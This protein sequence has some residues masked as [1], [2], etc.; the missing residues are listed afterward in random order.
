[1]L[2]RY[3]RVAV[4]AVGAVGLF[5]LTA[6]SHPRAQEPDAAAL[7]KSACAQCHDGSGATRAPSPDALKSRSPESVVDALT[8][9]AMR[10][11][12]LQLTGTERRTLAEYLSGKKMGG[13]LTGVG[14][15]ARC[16]TVPAMTDPDAGPLWNGWG[17]T[18]ENNHFQPAKDA[19]LPAS[20]VP[21]L[22]L[23]WAF[24][25]PDTTAA[26]SQPTIAGGRLFV[27]SQNSTVYSMNPKT[28]CVYWTF[29]AQGGVR[30]SVS[31]G[32]RSE[33]PAKYG[34]YFSDQKGYAFAVDAETGALLWSKKV[35]DHPLVR[36]TGSPAL[37]NG[38]L[39]VPTS[40]Y[41]ESGKPPNYNCCNFR[42]SIVALDAMTGAQKWKAYVI[43]DEPRLMG[44][45]K[46]GYESWGPAG[47][48]IWSAPTIDVK[49][50]AI[51]VGG[52]NT[53]AGSASQ[54]GTDGV[55]AFDLKTGK[56]L[57]TKQLHADDIFGCRSG[58]PN[59]GER[60][61]PDYDFGT[62]P[63]MA[64][65]ANGKDLIVIGQKSGIGWALDPDKHGD[66]VWQ[67]QAGRGSALGGIE[68]GS[69]LDSTQAY[70]PVADTGSQTPG[71]L[72]AVN[73]ATGAR[74]WFAAP[75]TP[76]KCGTPSRMCNPAQSAAITVIPGVVFSG[77]F[78]G[79][80][81][82]F[83]TKD[84]SVMWDFDTNREFL[85]VNGVA[86]HGAALNGPA[87]VVAG[88]MLYVSSGDYRSRPGNVLLA[89]D[90]ER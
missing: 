21:R 14:P 31:I 1:V 86:A 25:F 77:S 71:G 75:P 85:T 61:G 5:G 13:D 32:K 46:E 28:G 17:P 11:Q 12:G 88:G 69:A 90:V 34:A 49:R 63:T 43:E 58:E 55:D 76:L 7:F 15:A 81:R 72:H 35:E 16:T 66:I 20:D 41:E 30:A 64:H 52:G 36:L 56:L 40:S 80:I 57:W 42:G 2:H 74:A 62:S 65:L 18:V 51:Y 48:A 27:G 68:W 89:F 67:Y 23:K 47:G 24:G 50:N 78:D 60:Q 33:G 10:Y 79:G 38:V 4:V 22:T 6:V 53:Y 45:S 70:F 39:Y 54:P 19:G 9:G 44:K 73:L 84:G 37:Y 87:P 26:W 8:G 59:C 82:A 29:T 3:I 83:S